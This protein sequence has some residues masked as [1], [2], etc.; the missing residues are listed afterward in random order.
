MLALHVLSIYSSRSFVRLNQ[1]HVMKVLMLDIDG[2]INTVG[3]ELG[4]RHC[5]ML[6]PGCVGWPELFDPACL[7]YLRTI[8]ENTGCKIVVSSTWRN[9]ETIGSMK[10]WFECPVIREAII[11]KTPSF[12]GAEWDHLRDRRNRIQRGEEIKWWI[13]QH[14][15]V[16]RY[17]I[18]DDDSDMDV[19][20]DNFF[21]TC[22]HDGLKKEIANK[23]IMHLNH[24]WMIDHYR[25]NHALNDV[26]ADMF[27]CYGDCPSFDNVR[28]EIIKGFHTLTEEY[29]SKDPQ[30]FRPK[31]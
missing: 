1:R 11:D 4:L 9:G 15:E 2:V 18:L 19:V 27:T 5:L 16:T 30:R 26:L 24:D 25:M 17:A 6:D 8:V 13:E 3:G 7:Y 29:Y 21:K 22:S 20:R 23:V 31:K 14:P 28:A 10:A 12:H